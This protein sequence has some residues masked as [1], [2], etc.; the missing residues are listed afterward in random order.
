MIIILIFMLN[1]ILNVLGIE[2]LPKRSVKE[3][4]K[5]TSDFVKLSNNL[6]ENYDVTFCIGNEAADADSIISSLCYS[7]HLSRNPY[8]YNSM[9]LGPKLYIPLVCI[10]MDDLNLRRDVQILLE[11]VDIDY[12]HLIS[13]EDINFGV[14]QSP[15]NYKF[16]LLDHNE[17]N[18]NRIG[19]SDPNVIDV[20]EILD[21]HQD[22]NAHPN[23]IN[24]KRHVAFDKEKS[25]ALVGSA[26]T[27][28]CE[29]ILETSSEGFDEDLSI[30]LMGVILLDTLNMNPNA[31]KG[32]LRD[33]EAL[34]FLQS[35]V[36]IDSNELFNTLSNAKTDPLFW[37]NLS[38]R[39]CLRLDFKQFRFKEN[40]PLIGISSVLCSTE[41][42]L[43]KSD[44]LPS[45]QTYL[46]GGDQEPL[47]VLAIMNFIIDPEQIRSL[48]LFS[49]SNELLSEMHNYLLMNST[50]NQSFDEGI[51][52]SVQQSKFTVFN[53][54]SDID[55]ISSQLIDHGIFIRMYSQG[56]VKYS[57]KQIA[58]I[59]L[60]IYQQ[61]SIKK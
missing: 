2:M 3:F 20:E 45:I 47:E 50:T 38:A 49:Y 41:T 26:C 42:F 43:R 48:I 51:F 18:H 32:T 58:P 53:M 30:L 28:V 4:I 5:S 46:N 40:A 10:P 37:N 15:V 34:K 1:I 59:L 61:L 44:L 17:L 57:R 23:C 35:Q 52:T 8:C 55:L 19:I 7:Y 36:S 21:H 16:V 54:S 6:F 13:Y 25:T 60:Q 22:M 31:G 24:E 39:N 29:K 56:N 33:L 11:K 12:N 9:S 14:K 27:L